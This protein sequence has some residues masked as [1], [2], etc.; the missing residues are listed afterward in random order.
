M[1]ELRDALEQYLAIRRSLGFALREPGNILGKFVAFAEREDASHIT[2]NLVLHWV[3]EP[4]SKASLVT[5][6]SWVSMIRGFATWLGAADPRTQVPPHGL[7]PGRLRRKR[8]YI[9]ADTEIVRIVQQAS[10][11]TSRLG[12]RAL[13]YS[14]FFA[15]LSTTGMRMSEAIALDHADVDLHEGVLTIRRTKFKKSRLVPVHTTTSDALRHYIRRKKRLLGSPESPALFVSERGTRITQ[16][17]AR[18][19]F[20]LVALVAH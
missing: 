14:T 13:T 20:A 6:A 3:D 8:P 19:N 5:K 17:S 9:Y 15:L 11:L 10:R 16:F 2:T 18:Y 7:I 12:I 1:S 4:S